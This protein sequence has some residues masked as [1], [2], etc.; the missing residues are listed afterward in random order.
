MTSNQV[1]VGGALVQVTHAIE[2][3]AFVVG[4]GLTEMAIQL[5][6][7]V[8]AVHTTAVVVTTE[9]GQIA[10]ALESITGATTEDQTVIDAQVENLRRIIDDVSALIPG[11]ASK[12]EKGKLC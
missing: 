11:E 10:G 8:G 2:R 9:I 4:K 12:W 3:L 7:L 1:G 5:T 6:E